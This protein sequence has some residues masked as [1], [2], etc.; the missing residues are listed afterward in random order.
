MRSF[1]VGVFIVLTAGR[2]VAVD[3]DVAATK[4]GLSFGGKDQYQTCGDAAALNLQQ[5]WFYNWGHKPDPNARCQAGHRYAAEFVPMVWG[6]WGN[7]SKGWAPNITAQ[8]EA[9]GA[10]YLLGFNEPDNKGQSNLTPAQAAAYW[11]QLQALA[12]RTSPPLTLVSPGMTHWNGDGSVWLD[13]FFG[14]CSTVVAAC[15]PALIKF[16]AIHDYSGNA[17]RILANAAAT[18][19]KYGR[20]IWLTEFAVGSGKDR[21]RNDAFLAAVLP[22]LEASAHVRRYAWFSSR[23][24]PASWVAASSLLPSNASSAAPTST[25][26]L[27]AASTGRAAAASRA[28]ASRAAGTN[29][30]N[31][32]LRVDGSA[33]IADTGGV[34]LGFDTDYWANMTAPSPGHPHGENWGPRASILTMDFEDPL[35]RKVAA[36]LAPAFWRVG[37]TLADTMVFGADACARAPE[38]ALCLTEARLDA[39]FA[40]AGAV[41]A[42]VVL[43]L[44][45]LYG[46]VCPSTPQ[47][48]CTANNTSPWDS[49][50]ARALL[51]YAKAQGH[52][53]HAVGLGNELT[54][55]K[56][57]PGVPPTGCPPQVA[58]ET[59]ARDL[60]GL[61]A[62]IDELWPSSSGE[63]DT[64]SSASASAS[65]KPLLV[66]PDAGYATNLNASV[67]ADWFTRMLGAGGAAAAD[68]LAYHLYVDGHNDADAAAHARNA[69]FLDGDAYFADAVLLPTL[70]AAG[71]AAAHLLDA[72]L[73]CDETAF[74][75]GS[76][77][78]GLTDTFADTFWYVHQLGALA[79][80]GHTM[81]S[82]Q[83]LRGGWYE[84][85]N[86]TSA[87]PLPDFYAAVLW[88]RVMGARV[89][90][91]SL[92]G[93]GA[94]GARAFAHC[95]AEGDAGNVGVAVVNP[96]PVALALA[97]P[98]LASGASTWREWHLA[99]PTGG[100]GGGVSLNGGPPL[101]LGPDQRPRKGGE[102]PALAAELL[103]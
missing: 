99:P 60:Q 5:S 91:A 50:N 102:W 75:W 81:V 71:P 19:T 42:R 88:R 18:A 52:P 23:N 86:Q 8:W 51:A 55:G 39:A 89:L 15:D 79:A 64:P 26:R 56:C 10:R 31:A 20:P 12:A 43:T 82:R 14:N 2:A 54:N 32:S 9:A 22:R 44:N 80:R 1:L 58:P 37:G 34:F 30:P 94:V 98:P 101:R 11:P 7:C 62:V 41:G 40:W 38:G 72:G 77:R 29:A 47:R 49:S 27:Y 57:A 46:R 83:A 76:G 33:A 87:E 53:L 97:L 92:A 78:Y 28:A 6:C 84:L 36:Q 65:T 67:I 68:R 95:A 24:P 85:L 16:I 70:R 66:S 93:A 3:S 35:L 96:S 103:R 25:G 73:W 13:E 63:G 61:R 100:D 74:A 69:S 21:A 90:S 17:Q 4:R 45:G 59:Y 48:N